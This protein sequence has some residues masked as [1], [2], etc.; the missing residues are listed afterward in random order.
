MGNVVKDEWSSK[1]GQH[2]SGKKKKLHLTVWP[3]GA[4]KNGGETT[5]ND[6]LAIRKGPLNSYLDKLLWIFLGRYNSLIQWFIKYSLMSIR[7]HFSCG[8]GYSTAPHIHI[9]NHPVS[10]PTGNSRWC[11]RVNNP[12][13][14]RLITHYFLALLSIPLMYRPQSSKSLYIT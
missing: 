6:W 7:L 2:K 8:R 3:A 13:L 9:W 14:T 10:E 11:R 5:E 12:R 1:G 4:V